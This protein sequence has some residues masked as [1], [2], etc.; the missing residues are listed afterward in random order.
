MEKGAGSS[1]SSRLNNPSL[2][3]VWGNAFLFFFLQERK[4]NFF[5]H[6]MISSFFTLLF[7]KFFCLCLY[8]S[9][10][11]D[12]SSQSRS[13]VLLPKRRKSKPYFRYFTV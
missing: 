8:V 11:H 2:F 10:R 5:A 6:K 4:K 7:L 1:S 12:D 3:L 13:F 9:W